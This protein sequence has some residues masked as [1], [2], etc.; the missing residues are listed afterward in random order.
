MYK[1]GLRQ[2][3]TIVCTVY[4]T[5]KKTTEFQSKIIANKKKTRISNKLF[6]LYRT[7]IDTT[8]I[9]ILNLE[10]NTEEINWFCDHTIE[11]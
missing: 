3:C 7:T 6:T 8:E 10:T 5:E 11:A 9:F 2:S 1:K 4:V